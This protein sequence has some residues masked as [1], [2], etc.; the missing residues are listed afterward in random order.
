LIGGE[1]DT[2]AN[3]TRRILLL[4]ES[5]SLATIDAHIRVVRGVLSRYL[6]NEKSF[7]AESGRRYK[8]PRFL[9][10]DIVRYWRTIAVDYVNKQWG[11]GDQGWALRNIKLRF[12]RKL[13]F[14]SGLLA[15]FTS[16]LEHSITSQDELFKHEREARQAVKSHVAER[17]KLTPIDS[18]SHHLLSH[19]K[20]ATSD[21]IFSAYD[22]FLKR[23]NE[24]ES[25]KTLIDLPIGRSYSDSLFGE[26]RT[27]SHLF[28][29]GLNAM[30]FDDDER[31]RE[32]MRIYG[33]F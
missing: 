21:A 32:L 20:K 29:D 5:S 18:L 33:V 26:L 7:L 3:L 8:V 1:G 23:L 14:V 9:L 16:Y 6:D 17:L 22:T 4:L 27:V 2:N 12:S 11:R 10:N 24:P 15:C 28:Q 25:R 19:A 13:L 30:F 31:V